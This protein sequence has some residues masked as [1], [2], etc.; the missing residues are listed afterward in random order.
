MFNRRYT[1]EYIVGGK[2]KEFRNV[3][4]TWIDR[5]CKICKRF[6]GKLSGGSQNIC[7]KCAKK[8]KFNRNRINIKKFLSSN[9]G[10]EYNR[11]HGNMVYHMENINVGDYV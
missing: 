6:I 8:I 1:K 9:E 5:R 3:L 11:L 7:S 2:G 10:K 4:V